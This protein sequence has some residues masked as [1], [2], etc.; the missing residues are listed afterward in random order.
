MKRKRKPDIWISPPRLSWPF[1]QEKAEEF[2]SRYVGS[3]HSIPVPII[4]IVELTLKLEPIPIPGFMEKI[5]IDS[6]L[7]KDLK[8]ICIDNDLT[9]VILQRSYSCN[10]FFTSHRLGLLQL[11]PS[12]RRLLPWPEH[13]HQSTGLHRHQPG[14]L[15]SPVPVAVAQPVVFAS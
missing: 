4:E 15:P 1:I 6:F 2:R 12:P 3:V 9:I 10:C 7:T 11:L 14:P 8:N 13:Q 5:D